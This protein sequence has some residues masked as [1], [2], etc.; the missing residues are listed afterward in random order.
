[1]NGGASDDAPKGSKRERH[2][3]FDLSAW[4]YQNQKSLA[5]AGLF[6]FWGFGLGETDDS[7]STTCD[8]QE[9][10]GRQ[11][12][13]AAPRRGESSRGNRAR[14]HPPGP[15]KINHPPLGGFFGFRG[16]GVGE[17]RVVRQNATTGTFWS[18]KGPK[19]PAHGW[20]S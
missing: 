6:G 17:N 1:M 10:V 12:E 18:P 5:I 7:G 9:H 3:R 2:S 13:T 16:L 8:M 14:N 15:T 19:S 20:A 4:S 11:S